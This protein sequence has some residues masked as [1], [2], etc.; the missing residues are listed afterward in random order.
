MARI[1]ITMKIMPSSPEADLD[2]IK[3]QAIEKIKE[4]TEE[5]DTEMKT[6]YEEVA[7]GLKSINIIFVADESK[8]STDKLEEKI[9]SIE[10]VNS[11]EVIDVRR[12][13]G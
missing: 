12:T 5:E 11:A 8:G 13:I 2:K 1:V 9:K 4:Y 6:S 3:E 7:F 10:D